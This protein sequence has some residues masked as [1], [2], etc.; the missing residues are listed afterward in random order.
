LYIKCLF[1]IEKTTDTGPD[2]LELYKNLTGI[3]ILRHS[4]DRHWLSTELTVDP[5]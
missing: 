2:L 1:F 3:H 5:H 4:V